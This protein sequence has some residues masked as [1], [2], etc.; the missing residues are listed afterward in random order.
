MS[1]PKRIIFTGGGTAGHVTPNIALIERLRGEGWEIHYVGTAGG[2][3]KGLMQNVPGVQYHEISSGKLRR[4][5]SWQNFIDPF[6]VVKGLAQ[7]KK[8]MRDIRPDV[9]FSKGGFVSVPVVM[10]SGKIPVVAHESDYTP[11]LANRI[12]EPYCDTICTT[13]EDT[14]KYIKHGKG[15]YTGTPIRAELFSGSRARGLHFCGL[16][17]QKPVLLAMGGS[18]GAQALNDL[19]RQAL[20]R[21]LQKYDVIHLA[22]RGKVDHAFDQPGYIQFEYIGKEL[23]DLLAASDIVL[24]RAGAN[25]VFE[26]LAINKPAV[27]VPLTLAS[28]RGDQILNARYFEKKNYS[29][30]LD[31]D[32]ATP[33]SL[34]V[35]LGMLY[36]DRARFSK[37]MEEDTRSDGTET[38]LKLIKKAAGC[39]L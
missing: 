8:L 12:A 7:A 26:L 38:I 4:Y 24:S 16:D 19:L 25:A 13:F 36:A 3:E 11:G 5:F 32:T 33:E 21:L 18:L 29:I 9:V 20:P 22:G 34:E 14:V 1:E 17:G 37:I 31:Q 15:V 2:M 23:P 35:A 27:L 28:S 6:R 30:Y 39:K 10:A